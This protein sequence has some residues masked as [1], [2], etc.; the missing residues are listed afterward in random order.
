[1]E[2]MKGQTERQ[3]IAAAKA[4]QDHDA[5]PPRCLNCVYFR[6]EPHTK[7][8]EREVKQRNGKLKMVRIPAK[9]HPVRNPLVDR[10]SFG[11]FEVKQHHICN[12]WHG[13][14]GDSLE[15]PVVT[16]IQCSLVERINKENSHVQATD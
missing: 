16:Q 11:N 5:D 1:M 15:K 4:R 14:A 9:R 8:I 10:C 7:F 6:R 12:E 13:H 2:T 3:R